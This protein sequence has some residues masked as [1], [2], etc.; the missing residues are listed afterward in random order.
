MIKVNLVPAEIL[1]KAQQKQQAFQM[2]V[3]GAG[4]LL[5][6]A[7]VSAVHFMKA[8]RLEA[9]QTEKEAEFAKW[10]EEVKL[11]ENLEK[12]AGELR[13]RLKVVNDLLKGRP[14]YAYFLTDV[15][16]TVPSGIWIKTLNTT[17][18]AGTVR[19]TAVTADAASTEQIKEWVGRMEASGRFNAVEIGAVTS[20]EATP[21]VYSFS[22][23]GNYAVQL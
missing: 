15:V 6:I 14:L 17:S 10:Q 12:Q 21:K 8:K 2:G 9:Q 19:M 18:G 1:A 7:L 3:I 4:V 20:P 13:T 23:V 5:V 22:L 16:K 11:V